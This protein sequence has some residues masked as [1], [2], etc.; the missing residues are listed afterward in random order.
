[1]KRFLFW[2]GLFMALTFSYWKLVASE[3]L[4]GLGEMAWIVVIG[5]CALAAFVGVLNSA[6]QA[7][8]RLKL[9]CYRRQS[10]K[11]ARQGQPRQGTTTVVLN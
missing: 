8:M 10:R 2:A 7:W 3:G 6:P 5:L 4:I 9:S 1:M 11:K